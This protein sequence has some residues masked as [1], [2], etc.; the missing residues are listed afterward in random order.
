MICPYHSFCGFI[1]SSLSIEILFCC[2][3]FR[4][5][6]VNTTFCLV[7]QSDYHD[8]CVLTVRHLIVTVSDNQ[9]RAYI[10]SAGTDGRIAFW[11]I[12]DIA[13]ECV[14]SEEKGS[15]E[16][17]DE[18]FEHFQTGLIQA[19]MA[20]GVP[21]SHATTVE[22][23]LP[24][25]GTVDTESVDVSDSTTCLP[26]RDISSNSIPSECNIQ[27]GNDLS[28]DKFRRCCVN[29]NGRDFEKDFPWE[30]HPVLVLDAH[31]SG[32]NAVDVRMVKGMYQC[33][34]Y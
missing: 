10:L 14:Q 18:E 8:H 16:V 21:G 19:S 30:L 12:T 9:R 4:F 27:T 23:D 28:N 5:D 20:A 2:R 7:A 31:Q 29:G 26:E 11:D 22:E 25:F 15:S 33:I 1:T 3:I 32:V 24:E 6:E 13:T 34:K 17:T